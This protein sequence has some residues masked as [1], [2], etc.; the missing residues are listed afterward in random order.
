[1]SSST[2]S[3]SNNANTN[4]SRSQ[5]NPQAKK[6]FCK[7]CFDAKKPEKEYTNHFVKSSPGPE[8]IVICPTLLNSTCNYCKKEKAGHT[9]S[10]CPILAANQKQKEQKQKEYEQYHQLQQ[11]LYEE[12]KIA[13]KNMPNY[14][15]HKNKLAFKE[16]NMNNHKTTT[17]NHKNKNNKKLKDI[18]V[19]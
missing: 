6:P 8:G 18:L 5:T 7:V 19:V 14:N 13:K 3:R 15:K 10:Q 9:A 1:M 16:I 12:S 17:N 11:Q 2:N 4:N